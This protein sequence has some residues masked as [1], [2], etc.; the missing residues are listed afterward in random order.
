MDN[1][2]AMLIGLFGSKCT[3]R[4]ILSICFRSLAPFVRNS[5][6]DLTFL[7]V[8][9]IAEDDEDDE[10]EEGNENDDDDDNKEEIKTTDRI[11]AGLL[12]WRQS[13]GSNG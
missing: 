3:L 13:A 9:S 2:T 7:N 11:I 8:A 12:R 4:L 10:S 6:E 5:L 1:M